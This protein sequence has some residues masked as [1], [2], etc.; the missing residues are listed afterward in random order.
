MWA[1]N[2]LLR[3]ADGFVAMSRLIRQEF[4]SAGVPEERA[5]LIPHGVDT[6]RYRPASNEERVALRES[7]GWPADALVVIYT[8]RLLR[9]KGLEVLLTAFQQLLAGEGRALLVLV[10]SGKGESLSIEDELRQDVVRAGLESRV[11]FPGRVGSVADYLRAADIF[12]FPSLFEALG[13][14]LVEASA[15]GLA[16][17]G[18]RTGGIVDVI[19]EGRSGLL[20][21]PGDASALADAFFRLAGDEDLRRVLGR[22]A[23]ETVLRRFDS[24]DSLE[25]YMS[26]FGAVTVRREATP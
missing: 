21:S 4:L 9:G 23:R 25:R 10:G 3:D 26:L 2:L 19:E 6:E 12:A 14:S 22:R 24:R 13:L 5:F 18:S 15:C 16:C 20:V 17:V 7:L 11:H 1:R 8:G